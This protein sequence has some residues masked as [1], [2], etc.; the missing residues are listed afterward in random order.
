MLFFSIIIVVFMI[1]IGI[2][3]YF[4]AKR[5]GQTCGF[6]LARKRE[7][8]LLWAIA[9]LLCGIGLFFG[10][11]GVV[12]LLH[13][14]VLALLVQLV[15]FILRITAKKRYEDGFS[16]WKKLYGFLVVP[17]VLT[18]LLLGYDYYNMHN[19]VQTSYTVYTEKSIRPK[20]YRVALLSD[21]HFGIT[22]DEEELRAVCAEVSAEKPDLVVLGGDIIDDATTKDGVEA[23]FRTLGGIES[24]YGIF[25]VYGNHDR[26]MSLIR[27]EY[28]AEDLVQA[29]ESNGITILKDETLNIN[30]DLVLVGRDDRGFS[31]KKEGRAEIADLIKTVDQSRFVLTLDHQPKEYAQN[32]EAGTDLLLSGHT[33]G[34]QI[35]PVNWISALI[36]SDDAVYGH[37]QI[38]AD[39][40]AIVTSGLAGWGFPLKNAAPAEYVIVDIKAK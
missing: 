36:R 26:P 33:H 29:I 28:T 9:A 35:F 4:L 19:V 13:V 34:G 21:I 37:T 10:T 11:F 12:V 39:T 14:V 16:V 32:G 15:N 8:A 5:F 22:L 18:L 23:V 20:G 25:Y 3:L 31:L 40:Q 24:K 7:K 2:Y 1:A 30:D 38:D 6:S 27:S 17:L